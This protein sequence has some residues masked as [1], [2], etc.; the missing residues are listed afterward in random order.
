MALPRS[1][2]GRPSSAKLVAARRPEQAWVPR[3]QG[4]SGWLPAQCKEERKRSRIVSPFWSS[5]KRVLLWL[6]ETLSCLQQVSQVAPG[7]A[8]RPDLSAGAGR[9]FAGG[10]DTRIWLLDG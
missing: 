10:E 4:R 7:C 8:C 1:P 9:V 2:R 3:G 5:L 6:P